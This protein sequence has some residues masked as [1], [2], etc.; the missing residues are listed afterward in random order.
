MQEYQVT[1]E[2]KKYPLAR[3]FMVI[4]TQVPSGA[5]GTYLLTDVQLDR[6]L[7][8]VKSAYPSSEE[9][10]QII[11]NIDSIDEPDIKPVTNLEEIRL[12]QQ[13]VKSVHVAPALVEYITQLTSTVRNDP[14][15][16]WGPSTRAGIALFKCARVLAL[17]DGRDYVIPDDIKSLAFKAIEHRIRVKPEAQMDEITPHTVIERA[18]NKIP[19][20]KMNV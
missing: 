14:D 5:E 1:I 12:L 11:G 8:M 16:S 2:G 4:A 10:Q 6:F 17:I 19:V 3:P 20:P 7:L 13:Q 15:V 9:E 18:L